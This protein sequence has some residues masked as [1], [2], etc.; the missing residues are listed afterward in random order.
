V[1]KGRRL[2]SGF[3]DKINIRYRQFRYAHLAR[4]DAR[5]LEGLYPNPKWNLI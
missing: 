4:Q 5:I 1:G 3:L 2:M